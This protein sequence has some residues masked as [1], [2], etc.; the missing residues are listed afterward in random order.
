MDFLS[1]T[2]LKGQYG[3]GT[4]RSFEKLIGKTGKQILNWQPGQQRF[5]PKQVR[6]LREYLGK[7]LGR[8]EK[9]G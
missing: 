6:K 2:D 8:D 9:Y 3:V 7:P 5:T 1:K 4:N